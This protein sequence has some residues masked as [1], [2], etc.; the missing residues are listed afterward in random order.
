MEGNYHTSCH[1]VK[2]TLKCNFL[3]FTKNDGVEIA[4]LEYLLCKE[5]K[6]KVWINFVQ[7]N[8]FDIFIYLHDHG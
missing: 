5:S 8:A 7:L 4:L 6:S 2:L 1:G 3:K